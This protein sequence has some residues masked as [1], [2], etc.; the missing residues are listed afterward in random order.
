MFYF[1]EMEKQST[2]SM[3]DIHFTLTLEYFTLTKFYLTEMEKQSTTSMD[4]RHFTLTM[5]YFTE[6][7]N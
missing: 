2:T 6:I 5:F 1:T 7:E 3:D 4:N